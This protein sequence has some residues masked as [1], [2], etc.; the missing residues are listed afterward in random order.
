[1]KKLLRLL[2]LTAV[3]ALSLCA[4]ALAANPDA[5][6][7]LVNGQ[8]VEFADAAPQIVDG[9]TYIPLRATFTALERLFRFCE[10]K[11]PDFLVLAGDIYNQENYSAKAQLALR[12]GGAAGETERRSGSSISMET[13]RQAGFL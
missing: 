2:A 12:D 13:L 1:M 10:E 11:R 5:P 9:R 7:V 6:A 4:T 3:V 8:A